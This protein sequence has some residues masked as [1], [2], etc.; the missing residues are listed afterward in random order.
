MP[1]SNL[2]SGLRPGVCLSTN[3]PTTPYEGQMIYETDTDMLAIWNGAAWRYVGSAIPSATSLIGGS[4]LQVVSVYDATNR[5]TTS[6]YPALSNLYSSI[7][8]K[9]ASSKILVTATISAQVDSSGS[10][11][12]RIGLYGI[13]YGASSTTTIYKTRF[14]AQQ[15]GALDIFGTVTMSILHSPATTS[16]CIYNILFGR[17]NS[18]YNNTVTINADGGNGVFSNSSIVLMEI[19]G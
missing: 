12:N 19:A 4:V 5:N 15:S 3:R 17:Y 16:A 9:S 14:G 8:P 11:T 6:D 7:T 2:S 18:T 13:S 1:I 10:N